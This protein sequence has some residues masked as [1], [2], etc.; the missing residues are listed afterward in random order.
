MR[1]RRLKPVAGGAGAL[2][3]CPKTPSARLVALEHERFF[4]ADRPSFNLRYEFPVNEEKSDVAH[5]LPRPFRRIGLRLSRARSSRSGDHALSSHFGH[6]FLAAHWTLFQQPGLIGRNVNLARQVI[7]PL[8]FVR[9]TADAE[10]SDSTPFVIHD[11]KIVRPVLFHVA[12]RPELSGDVFGE[13]LGDNRR[14][15]QVCLLMKRRSTASCRTRAGPSWA[16]SFSSSSKTSTRS[17][18]R[19]ATDS[20]LVSPHMLIL[21][22]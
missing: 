11:V 22:S 12:H 9:G 2:R 15:D 3:R 8:V 1:G 6:P 14:H 19:L 20:S 5:L 17:N 21:A 4:Q 16:S 13:L 7:V 10:L 18:R